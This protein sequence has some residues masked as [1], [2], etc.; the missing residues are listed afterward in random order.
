MASRAGYARGG[1]VPAFREVTAH[2][3]VGCAAVSDGWQRQRQGARWPV[4]TCE[5][6][7]LSGGAPRPAPEAPVASLT[8]PAGRGGGQGG[9]WGHRGGATRIV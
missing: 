8:W 1:G 5:R 4:G 2:D 9:A 6:P 7:S 3:R